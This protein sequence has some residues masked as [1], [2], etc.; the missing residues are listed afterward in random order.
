MYVAR[1]AGMRIFRKK[2]RDRLF[3]VFWYLKGVNLH[4]FPLFSI[5]KPWKSRYTQPNLG[6][7]LK[8]GDAGKMQNAVAMMMEMQ[9]YMCNMCMRSCALIH[10]RLSSTPV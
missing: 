8:K 10:G 1:G 2:L 6:N 5:D 4:L 9:M 7:A 3:I